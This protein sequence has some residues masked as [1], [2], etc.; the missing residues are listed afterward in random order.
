MFDEID[1]SPTVLGLTGVFWLLIVLFVWK[2]QIGEASWSMANKLLI[3][4]LSLPVCFIVVQWQLN[5][6]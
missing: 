4:G 6:D 5:K 2:I 3:T 1:F